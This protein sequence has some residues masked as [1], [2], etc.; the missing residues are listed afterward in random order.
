MNHSSRRLVL[1]LGT[2]A[3]AGV[4]LADPPRPTPPAA[5]PVQVTFVN[6]V[7][8]AP[9]VSLALRTSRTDPGAVA[10]PSL[11]SLGRATTGI[12]PG[13]AQITLRRAGEAATAPA[14]GRAMPVLV[15]A[16]QRPLHVLMGAD[17]LADIASFDLADSPAP[18][19]GGGLMRFFNHV[20]NVDAVDLCTPG[21]TPAAPGAVIWM[22]TGFN[23][24]AGMPGANGAGPVNRVRVELGRPLRWQVREQASPVCSGRVIAS[25]EVNIPTSTP[26]VIAIAMGDANGRD[27]LTLML[28]PEAAGECRPVTLRR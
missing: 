28:C 13:F 15:G 21:A 19:A 9:A 3:V 16:G 11:P 26:A 10:V 8:G 22:N 17:G 2:L 25:G 20:A 27:P 14:F 6:L 7:T 1:A 18:P 24:A 23:T 5:A 4:A 12:A